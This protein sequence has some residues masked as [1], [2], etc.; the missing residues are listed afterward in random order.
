M[1]S[2]TYKVNKVYS[3]ARYLA[4]FLFSFM[5]WRS[6]TWNL[7]SLSHLS[8]GSFCRK[9]LQG[10][11]STITGVTHTSDAPLCTV[12]ICPV[13]IHFARH[14]R[15]S[16]ENVGKIFSQ[17]IPVF[18][19][20]SKSEATFGWS[21]KL[22]LLCQP[23]SFVFNSHSGKTRVISFWT[24]MAALIF[25]QCGLLMLHLSFGSPPV[26]FMSN[27]PVRLPAWTFAWGCQCPWWP[28]QQSAAELAWCSWRLSSSA[29][30]RAS[31]TGIRPSPLSTWTCLCAW[32]P[33]HS[34]TLVARP[35]GEC[36][37]WHCGM[38]WNWSSGRWCFG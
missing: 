30:I 33:S 8:N 4:S 27:K 14:S 17:M 36:L 2:M 9:L 5:A 28:R 19:F 35:A 7:Q 6:F 1:F 24:L 21:S 18:R 32:F 15:K 26:M 12:N 3:Q 31:Q 25:R 23:F 37:A 34:M 16:R 11:F 13:V 20:A 38:Q 29:P 10:N 22:F